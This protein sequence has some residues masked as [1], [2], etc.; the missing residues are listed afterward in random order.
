MNRHREGIKSV[1][2]TLHP[3][4]SR[5]CPISDSSKSD[6][7][8]SYVGGVSDAGDDGSP[9][10]ERPGTLTSFGSDG[11]SRSAN[12]Q[13]SRGSFSVFGIKRHTLKMKVNPITDFGMFS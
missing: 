12:S 5:L 4:N 8:F 9:G 11:S 7:N 3:P 6:R 13:R 10:D 1:Y 2:L